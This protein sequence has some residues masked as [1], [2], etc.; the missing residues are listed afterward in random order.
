[1][2]NNL[3]KIII[4]FFTF[5]LAIFILNSFIRESKTNESDITNMNILNYVPSN[6]EFTILFK[7]TNS[8][9]RKYINEN[10]SN[11]KQD[12]INIIKN[13]IISYLGFDLQDKIEDLYDNELALTF[14]K[15]K[16]NTND[17]LLIFKLKKNKGIANLI[18]IEKEFNTFNKIIEIKRN[19]KKNYISHIFQT[20]DN[21]IIASSNKSLIDSS[22]ESKNNTKMFLSKNLIP[23]NINLNA[24][25]LLSI[26]KNPLNLESQISNELIT[27]INMEDNKIKLRSFSKNINKINTTI[28]NNQVDNIKDIIVSKK[29]SKYNKSINFL[30]NDI[31]QKE[32]IEEISNKVNDKILFITNNDNWVLYFNSKLS[33]QIPIDQLNFLQSYTKEDLYIDNINYSIYRNNSLKVI[34]N[35]IIYDEE[36]PIFSLKD[37]ENTYISNNFDALQ[38][39][40]KNFSLTDNYLNISN[41]IN[42]YT[43]ILN[44]RFLIKN[45]NNKELVKY[46][47]SLKNIQYFLNTELFSLEDIKINISHIIPDR[48]E[49]LY[50]ESNL[51]IL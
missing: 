24:I 25:K 27:I 43:Y 2:N 36:K 4:V 17:M 35:D 13:S 45:I 3:K 41:Q 40:S 44:D 16:L 6:Y 39:I 46:Y 9:I 49:T 32:L 42:P 33:N 28:M 51:K 31:N 20:K 34:D 14:V 38:N 30:Y 12:E 37:E 29:Y 5:F 50:L 21:Y 18:N 48:H 15:N 23:D 19:G 1:M 11:E 8:D 26:S 47:K 10:I 22:L 7:S